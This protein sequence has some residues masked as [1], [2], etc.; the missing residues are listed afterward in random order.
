VHAI[1]GSR[2]AQLLK[3]SEAG[4]R[5]LAD[6]GRLPVVDTLPDGTRLFSE[7]AIHSLVI[8]KA[9]GIDTLTGLHLDDVI[10]KYRQAIDR[11]S[12]DHIPGLVHIVPLLLQ[13]ATAVEKVALSKLVQAAIVKGA[14]DSIGRV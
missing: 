9:L 7:T 8:A 6:T 1:T 2:V 12:P 14:W 13:R 10:Q 3:L 11:V 5:K 4:V